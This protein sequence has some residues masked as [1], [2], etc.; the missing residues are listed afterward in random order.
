M[1]EFEVKGQKIKRT[2]RTE[3]ATDSVNYL[4]AKFNF[5]AD[6]N[7]KVKTAYF[8]REDAVY[9]VLVGSDNSCIVPAEV[10]VRTESRYART[11]G[12]TIYV[13][14][15]GTYNTTVITTNEI[16]VVLNLSGYGEAEEPA[17]PTEDIHQQILT[18]YADATNECVEAKNRLDN[19]S[20]IFANA[21]KGKVSG[22]IVAIDDASPVEHIPNVWV[23]GK[24]L[25][26]STI[27]DLA[28][29]SLA[30]GTTN[31]Y[32]FPLPH[33][34]DGIKYTISAEILNNSIGYF[35]IEESN[36]GFTTDNNIYSME[37]GGVTI[38]KN[39]NQSFYVNGTASQNLYFTL[40]AEVVLKKKK[41]ILSGCADGGGTD[42]FILYLT[43][44]DF[45]AQD[46]GKGAT[47]NYTSN[48]K[49]P[50]KLA[51]YEGA[52]L[53]NALFTPMIRLAENEDDGFEAYSGEEY[54]PLTDGIVEEITSKPNMTI[55][56]D[57]QDVTI[58][59]EYN[60]DTNKVIEK[61]TDAI[62]AL[63]GT[64]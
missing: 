27:Y 44:D 64:I 57:T 45:Y 2:D 59:C 1:L 61:L 18:A 20:N 4:K 19:V 26:P 60:K 32:V 55:L 21:L 31:N 29:W 9:S 7:G 52:T 24:N 37:Y 10:L 5:D 51:I 53:N 33:L 35:Y 8:K 17:D 41:Y 46:T 62:T 47:F 6:W 38:T 30:T 56:T 23:H 15:V 49:V 50:L 40:D 16:G 48:L 22:E 11:Q 36:D 28:N 39:K 54:I 3:P 12:N 14:V 25:L 58:E 63:G 42:T 43:N 13:T 34:K